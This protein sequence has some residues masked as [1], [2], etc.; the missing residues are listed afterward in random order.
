MPK[1]TPMPDPHP[2]LPPELE[3]RIRVLE[4]DSSGAGDLNRASWL[5]LLLFGVA[6]PAAL[7]LWGWW[8]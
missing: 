3:R 7:L 5:W 8:V 2:A 1:P 4:S 6:L